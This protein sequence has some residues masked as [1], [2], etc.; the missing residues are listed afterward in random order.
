MFR[1]R[2]VKYQSVRTGLQCHRRFP[3]HLGLQLLHLGGGQVGRVGYDQIQFSFRQSLPVGEQIPQHRRCGRF[4]QGVFRVL[5]QIPERFGA[6]FK[7]GHHGIRAE[8]LDAQPQTACACTEVEH[9][10]LLH[11]RQQPGSS[12]GHH[13][14]IRPGAEHPR[15]DSQLEIEERPAAAKILQRFAVGAAHGQRF[16]PIGLRRGQGLVCQAEIRP[17]D[18]PEQLPGVKIRIRAACRRQPCFDLPH[19]LLRAHPRA[20]HLP[21]SGSSG[22]TGVTAAMAT[23]IIRSSGSKTVRCC[24]QMPG[25]RMIR[26]ARLSDRPHHLSSS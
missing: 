2:A 26:V 14:R 17:R 11:P 9:L 1:D 7:A 19:G 18:Q 25:C 21:S 13:L 6:F 24:T 16:Q 15:P 22:R 4:V 12:L 8:P 10:R 20:Y 3:R 23:S 5:L